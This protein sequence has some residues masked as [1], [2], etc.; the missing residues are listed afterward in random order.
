MVAWLLNNRPNYLISL[1]MKQALWAYFRV[2]T[3]VIESLSI[4][5]TRNCSKRTA[6]VR[7]D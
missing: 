1:T 2:K 7:K 4:P 6:N 5:V 3:T